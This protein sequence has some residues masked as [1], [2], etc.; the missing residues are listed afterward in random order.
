MHFFFLALR[1][2]RGP[3]ITLISVYAIAVLGLTLIPGVDDTGNPA[4]MDFFHAFYFVSFMGS[5]IGFG[6]IP[7]PFTDAQRMWVVV[8]IYFSV[9]AWL[10]TIGRAIALAQEPAFRQALTEGTFERA[11]DRIHDP[12]YI[13]CGYGDTG[14]LL[15]DGFTERGTRT[16]VVDMEQQRINDL[17][18]AALEIYV[19]GL[20]ADAEHPETLISAG[21]KHSSCRGVIAVTSS[22]EINLKV[23]ITSKLLQPDLKVICR[24]E[25]HDVGINMESFGTDH[26]VNPFDIFADRLATA[27]HSPANYI[28]RR[29]LTSPSGSSLSEPLY[30]PR[31][32]WILCGYGRFG[33]AVDRFLSFEGVEATVIEVD[34]KQTDAPYD[35]IIGRGT[36]AVTLLEANVDQAAGIIAGTDD[37]TNNL[38]I[39]MTA[40][41]INPDLFIV[42]RQ[43]RQRNSALFEAAKLHVVMQRS[44]IIARTIITRIVNPLL[45]E[46]L[47]RLPDD[48]KEWSNLLSSRIIGACSDGAHTWNLT[49]IRSN[50]P[51]LAVS[52]YRGAA[53][54]LSMILE[55]ARRCG[56][57]K[58]LPLPLLLKRENEATMLPDPDIFLQH[59]DQL[60]FCGTPSAENR[61]TWIA[62]NLNALESAIQGDAGEPE[63]QGA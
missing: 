50:C 45:A 21:L 53:I 3:L 56:G 41:E 37:D 36:E 47:D 20:C 15:V 57:E 5:T 48:D 40:R 14:R 55:E 61:V 16:T 30:P 10:Y 39:I 23:A 11:V 33:K 38:S 60:L 26:I 46:F 63:L 49:I 34:P 31:G 25:I 9:V 8:C 52:L 42:A 43:N 19:P 28:I 58:S 1:R 2:L 27:L 35:T 54:S 4:R 22:D 51:A 24:S 18:L 32:R 6:E 17:E 62:G 12:F 13:V 29:W 7:Y 59:G 44:D